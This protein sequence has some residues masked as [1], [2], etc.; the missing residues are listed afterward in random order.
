MS[1]IYFGNL[2]SI[3]ENCLPRWLNY[4]H[5][6]S[7]M[8][9]L[10]ADDRFVGFWVV[11]WQIMSNSCINIRQCYRNRTSHLQLSE[12]SYY[13]M[14]AWPN[15]FKFQTFTFSQALD[16]HIR[17]HLRGHPGAAVVSCAFWPH[18]QFNGQS[19]GRA[20]T[21][22]G[23]CTVSVTVRMKYPLWF[24]MTIRSRPSVRY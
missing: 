6:I 24:W 19:L 18:V 16:N 20:H 1:E 13:S 15:A 11:H 17:L 21:C 3:T 22:Y 2:K 12:V 8:K 4:A 23:Y 9:S 14:P 10:D 5:I 7:I